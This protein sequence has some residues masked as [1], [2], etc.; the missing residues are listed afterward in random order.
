MDNRVYVLLD[1]MDGKAKQV[2]Q[3]LRKSPG[4]VMA[5]AVEGPPDVIMVVEASDRQKLAGLTVQ[6]L[7]AV[8][9]MTENF[10]LLPAEP[11]L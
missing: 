11:G 10:L 6:A 4:V 1:I 5:D 9:S 8:E 7:A 2:P 3:V